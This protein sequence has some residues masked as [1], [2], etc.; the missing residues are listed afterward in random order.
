MQLTNDS[1]TLIKPQ[2]NFISLETT[3]EKMIFDLYLICV[4]ISIV[5]F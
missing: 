2:M 4:T 1:Y 3:K 5:F